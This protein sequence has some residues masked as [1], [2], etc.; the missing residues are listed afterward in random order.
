MLPPPAPMEVHV[1]RKHPDIRADD[2]DLRAHHG[3]A[4]DDDADIKARA[5]NIRRQDVADA[6]PGGRDLRPHDA[7]RRPGEKREGG[8]VMDQGGRHHT[9]G[10]GHHHDRRFHAG[11]AQ[12]VFQLR[13]IAA[14]QRAE[15]GVGRRCRHARVFAHCRRD[16]V[17]DAHEGV[18]TVFDRD[19]AKPTLVDGVHSGKERADGDRVYAFLVRLLRREPG[20][21]REVR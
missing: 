20:L 14:G 15:S 8:P 2:R 13:Q 6:H 7:S 21:R 3:P 12:R 16:F 1:D 5:A 10:A 4:A 11:V 18:G 17:R 9:A 19:F